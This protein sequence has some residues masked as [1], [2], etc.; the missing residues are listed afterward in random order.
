MIHAFAS[1]ST[2]SQ[3]HVYFS[4]VVIVNCGALECLIFMGA[5]NIQAPTSQYYAFIYPKPLRK[6]VI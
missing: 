6:Y 1:F 3:L 4:S 5:T 2:L